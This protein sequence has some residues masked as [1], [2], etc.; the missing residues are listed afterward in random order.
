MSVN[1]LYQ[2][3]ARATDGRSAP[4]RSTAARREVDSCAIFARIH[5]AANTGR[6]SVDVMRL[7]ITDVGRVALE[8]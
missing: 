8:R 2:T 7:R 4:P 3:A 5:A 1:V 6:R